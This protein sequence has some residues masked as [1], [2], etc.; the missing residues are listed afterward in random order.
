LS[1]DNQAVENEAFLVDG[2]PKPVEF[3]SDRND[4]FIQMSRLLASQRSVT[5][6]A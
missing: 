5:M 2:A 1:I 3:A 6:R 4:D